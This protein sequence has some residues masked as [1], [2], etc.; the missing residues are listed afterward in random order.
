MDRDPSYRRISRSLV[1][2]HPSPIGVVEFYG[3]NLFG[4][5]PATWYDYLLGALYRA[6][7]TI[8]AVPFGLSFDHIA[9]AMKLLEER[10][11]V[12][13]RL[14]ELGSVPH[15]WVGHSLGC[16]YLALM[17]AYTDPH[18][19]AFAPPGIGPTGLRGTLNEPTLLIAPD[20]SDTSEA[21]PVVG[22]LLD[23]V[24]LGV[25]PNRKETQQIIEQD[26]L[27]GLTGVI[28]FTG[29]GTAGN[30]SQPPEQSDVAW[31]LQ[32]LK[33]RNPE[34]VLH[35][36]L[37]GGHLVP[38]GIRFGDLVFEQQLFWP[39]VPAEPLAPF[40]QNAIEMLDQLSGRLVRA[41]RRAASQHSSVA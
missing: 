34:G 18:T 13:E 15:F 3:G 17:E 39:I 28:S 12:R 7:Y 14:P 10:D 29:D 1:A 30:A 24:G 22:G 4:Q 27:F 8:I 19:A 41:L 9:V 35:R 32:M 31:F 23:L 6:G 21:V 25:R 5:I 11:R 16:K 38:T 20:I 37:D 26:A 33:G 40:E 36:E 2:S